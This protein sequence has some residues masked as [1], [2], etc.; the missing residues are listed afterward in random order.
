[1][2]QRRRTKLKLTFIFSFLISLDLYLIVKVLHSVYLSNLEVKTVQKLQNWLVYAN[3]VFDLMTFNW[4]LYR[5]TSSCWCQGLY[6][7]NLKDCYF[8]PKIYLCYCWDLLQPSD[9]LKPHLKIL[10]YL[11]FDYINPALQPKFRARA[12]S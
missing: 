6:F 12:I 5:K 3:T 11:K 4:F 8:F 1:M 10:S 2:L 7:N 9:A